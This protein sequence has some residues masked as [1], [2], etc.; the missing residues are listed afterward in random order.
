MRGGGANGKD[1]KTV[2]VAQ[3][4]KLQGLENACCGSWSQG[5]SQ[6][7]V[8]ELGEDYNAAKSIR[9]LGGSW[10]IEKEDEFAF[11]PADTWCCQAI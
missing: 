10:F 3:R 5:C 1:K 9:D 6:S 2:A 8:L 11:K 7:F 4:E